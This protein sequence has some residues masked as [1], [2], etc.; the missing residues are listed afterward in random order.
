MYFSKMLVQCF[1]PASWQT[2]YFVQNLCGNIRHGSWSTPSLYLNLSWIIVN[3]TLGNKFKWNLKRILSFSFKKMCLKMLSTKCQPFCP[4]HLFLVLDSS[5]FSDNDNLHI[6]L[7]I[8]N[9][10]LSYWCGLHQWP[11]MKCREGTD[12]DKDDFCRDFDNIITLL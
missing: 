5:I 4:T 9:H 2:C 11:L 7:M 3:W 6:I 8:T 1:L 12:F 10:F